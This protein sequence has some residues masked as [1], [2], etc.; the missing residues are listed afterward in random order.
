MTAQQNMA[1]ISFIL[2]ILSLIMLLFG[3]GL[4]AAALG[5]ITA[6]LSKGSGPM[7]PKAKSGFIMSLIG[8]IISL[9]IIASS[10]IMIR[11]G[12]LQDAYDQMRE[13]VETTY[14]GDDTDELVKELEEMLGITPAAENGGDVK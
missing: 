1:T 11:T 14:S 7:L 3:F 9:V 10:I 13:M 2:G 5:L 4:P 12:A 6:H 8:L